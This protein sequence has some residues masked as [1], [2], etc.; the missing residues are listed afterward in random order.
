MP[1]GPYPFDYLHTPATDGA[2]VRVYAAMDGWTNERFEDEPTARESSEII[3]L[4]PPVRYEGRY[5]AT[6]RFAG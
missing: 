3:V 5:R 1:R 2:P 4:L 6:I